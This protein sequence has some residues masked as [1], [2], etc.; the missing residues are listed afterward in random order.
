MTT[1]PG[2]RLERR[3]VLGVDG[4]APSKSALARAVRQSR[5]TGAVVEAVIAWEF[6]SV[7]GYPMLVADIDWEDLAEQI[8][9]PSAKSGALP[10]RLRYTARWSRGTPR[11]C[12]SMSQPMRSC[13]SLAAADMADSSR[14]CLA[15]SASIAC[16]TLGAPS[17]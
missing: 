6:P 3:I 12:C 13:S 16:T 5:L 10:G 8:V 7:T 11:R 14:R 4:S 15:R 1:E 2:G 9:M 17:W